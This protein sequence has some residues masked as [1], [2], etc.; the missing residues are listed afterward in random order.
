MPGTVSAADGVVSTVEG[1]PV[2][3]G[4][5]TVGVDGDKVT[6]TDA[7]G[8]TVTVATP[9]VEAGNGVVHVVD[10]VLMPK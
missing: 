5:L 1:Q 2:K 6:L 8:N 9:D 3:V 10:S 4:E 7:S